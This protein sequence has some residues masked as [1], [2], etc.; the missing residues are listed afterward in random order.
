MLRVE[1][2]LPMLK[3]ESMLAMM[4][5]LP[6]VIMLNQPFTLGD[7]TNLPA[8]ALDVGQRLR[9]GRVAPY[10]PL[11]ASYLFAQHISR[12]SVLLPL[13]V[14]NAATCGIEQRTWSPHLNRAR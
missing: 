1:P 10:V 11:R 7:L 9:R 4:L 8:P 2:A 3:T 5:K 13:V 6:M 14:L 12:R